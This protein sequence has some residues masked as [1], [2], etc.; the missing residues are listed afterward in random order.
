MGFPFSTKHKIKHF[1]VVV[2]LRRLKNVQKSLMHV[3][4]FCFTNQ[5]YC[6]FAVLVPVAVVVGYVFESSF[7]AGMI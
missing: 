3:Q 2:V 1:D 4:S 6:F 7:S 5:S